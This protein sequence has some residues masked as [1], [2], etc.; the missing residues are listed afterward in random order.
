[1]EF[2][3]KYLN[4]RARLAPYKTKT[5]YETIKMVAAAES[6]LV[7]AYAIHFGCKPGIILPCPPGIDEKN[8]TER[9]EKIIVALER[10]ESPLK[11]KF[12]EPGVSLSDHSVYV[13]GST[14]HLFY[15]RGYV[16]YDWPERNVDTIGH[17][18]TENLVD[19]KIL[20]P[21]ITIEANGVEGH[22]IWSPSVIRRGDT[23]YM[24]YTGVNE[25][26]SQSTCLATSTDLVHWKKYEQNP[27]YVPG[28]WSPWRA[29]E[30]S[31]NRDVMVLEDG[32]IYY[33]YYCVLKYME[34]G[35]LHNAIG[36]AS[37]KDLLHWKHENAFVLENCIYMPESPFVVCKD[38]K[39]YLFYTNCGVGTCYAVSDDPV[40]G[41]KTMG[42][43]IT[44]GRV[45]D[46]DTA[47]VPS[48][49]EVFAFHGKWYITYATRLPGSEQ[50]LEMKEFIW[51][52]DGTVS[53]GRPVL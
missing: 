26:I 15:N 6:L 17:A 31:D 43:L 30:W 39:Y 53:T 47:H 5:D 13:E 29:D 25:K 27:V 20:P 46:G 37:S 1:M 35:S 21:A 10:G 16:G 45:N 7:R 3:N 4:L 11:G 28:S 50:Y 24:L 41:F 44:E 23:Y 8:L 48:C 52:E 14:V 2:Y 34:D 51:N 36:V 40:R 42:E 38:G 9:A 32:G 49:S 19:W 22:G 33:M 18:V 12:T